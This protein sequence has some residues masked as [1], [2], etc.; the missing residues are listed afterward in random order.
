M[1]SKTILNLNI[2]EDREVEGRKSTNMERVC[3]GREFDKLLTSTM[4]IE[5]LVTDGHLGISAI[6]S[7]LQLNY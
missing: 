7:M 5:D 3:F 2:V 1:E 6:M 4:K